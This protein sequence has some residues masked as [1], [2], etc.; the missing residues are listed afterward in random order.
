MCIIKSPLDTLFSVLPTR[1]SKYKKNF[2][3]YG[4]NNYDSLRLLNDEHLLNE[5]GKHSLS[6]LI[7]QR[8]VFV[9]FGIV[10][11]FFLLLWICGK[12]AD[13]I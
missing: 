3:E 2:Q 13:T 9:V 5:L 10:D 4:V 1:Y 8:L 11:L 12:I 6:R 7:S